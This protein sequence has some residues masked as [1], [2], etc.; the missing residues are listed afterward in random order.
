MPGLDPGIQAAPSL[1]IARTP[2]LDARVKPVHDEHGA[3]MS[4]FD[5]VVTGRVV[6]TDR[7]IDDGWVAIRDGLVER[8]GSRSAALGEG[9]ARFRRR[10]CPA[11]RHQLAGPFALAEGSGG[12]HLVDPRRGRG[13]RHHHRRHAV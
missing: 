12:F 8:V 10:L 13:R 6:R 9:E 2:A 5:L 7:V 11:R 1:I 4:D 3:A